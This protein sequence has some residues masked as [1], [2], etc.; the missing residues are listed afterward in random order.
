[1]GAQSIAH[2][3]QNYANSSN[4]ISGHRCP[5]ELWFFLFEISSIGEE[6]KV[7]KKQYINHMFLSKNCWN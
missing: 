7:L 4:S 1:V 5:R 2:L 3:G 6:F